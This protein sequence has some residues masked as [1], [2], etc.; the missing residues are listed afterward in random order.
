MSLFKKTLTNFAIGS[1]KVDSSLKQEILFPGQNT[2]I[3]IH[4]YGGCKKEKIDYI[5]LKLCCCYTEKIF[6][7]SS[8]NNNEQNKKIKQSYTL[9]EWSS[10]Y[11]FLIEARKIRN[12]STTLNVPWNTPVTIG[13]AKVWLESKMKISM[14]IDLIN[15][16]ILTVRPDPLM[17]SIFSTL[18]KQ[19]LRIRKVVCKTVQGFDDLPFMQ[20]FEFI[21]IPGPYYGCWRGLEFIARR[22]NGA[23]KLWIDIDRNQKDSKKIPS[24]SFSKLKSHLEIPVQKTTTEAKMMILEY[25][26]DISSQHVRPLF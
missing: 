3:T 26:D 20:K 13:N 5:G 22:T 2:N 11:E 4:V 6:N 9:S 23:L 19:S 25:L 18:E 7:N 17:D 8:K 15:K 24:S 16:K 12:F 14:K 1:A 10:P 21:P